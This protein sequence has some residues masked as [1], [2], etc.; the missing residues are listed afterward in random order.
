MI[1][2]F[3]RLVTVKVIGAEYPGLHKMVSDMIM[4][5]LCLPEQTLRANIE[6]WQDMGLSS[7][8]Q[9]TSVAKIEIILDVL[10]SNTKIDS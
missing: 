1:S 6:T 2:K 9:T 5:V 8:P 4:A 10:I 3:A 7:R